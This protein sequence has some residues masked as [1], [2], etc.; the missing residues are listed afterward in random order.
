V[1]SQEQA[2]IAIKIGISQLI[3]SIGVPIV[4]TLVNGD[5]HWWE[6]GGLADTVFFVAI[7]N[8]L[9]PISAFLD[10]WNIYLK[11]NRKIFE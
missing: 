10:P 6:P 8:I 5:N 1:C 2:N 9:V 7:L 11:V 4:V 3:N